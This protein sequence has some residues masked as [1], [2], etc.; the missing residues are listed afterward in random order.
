MGRTLLLLEG[1]GT[2][3]LLLIVFVFL[4]FFGSKKIPGMARTLGKSVREF[5]DA[6]KG[7]Q[8]EIQKET[9]QIKEDLPGKKEIN[10][11]IDNN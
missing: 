11:I 4:L 8:N 6:A 3:E 10:K 7:I 2:G 9:D 5:K 1:I